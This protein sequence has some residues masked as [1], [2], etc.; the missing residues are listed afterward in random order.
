MIFFIHLSIHGLFDSFHTMPIV[1]C[2]IDYEVT[3]I[4]LS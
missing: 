2:S 1:Y 4:C 3:Y